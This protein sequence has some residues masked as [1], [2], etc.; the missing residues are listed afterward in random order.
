MGGFE[1]LV[2]AGFF[3]AVFVGILVGVFAIAFDGSALFQVSRIDRGFLGLSISSAHP[4]LTDK[5]FHKEQE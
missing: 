4:G 5:L 3:S 2:T 1:E